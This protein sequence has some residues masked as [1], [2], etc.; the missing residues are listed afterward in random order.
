MS[1]LKY[2]WPYI[3]YLT[4]EERKS[5]TSDLPVNMDSFSVKQLVPTTRF[6]PSSYQLKKAPYF[7]PEDLKRQK[8]YEKVAMTWGSVYFIAV[9][10]GL[11]NIGSWYR[12]DPIKNFEYF[13]SESW[14]KYVKLRSVPAIAVVWTVYYAMSGV[15]LCEY[16]W[17]KFLGEQLS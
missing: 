3:Q 12:V 13:K 2:E 4:I 16:P 5:Y 1:D 15:A 11:W 10:A 17:P 8:H 7:T 14:F 9:S 6:N